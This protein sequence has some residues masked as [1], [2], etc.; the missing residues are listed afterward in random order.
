MQP[1]ALVLLPVIISAWSTYVRGDE[2]SSFLLPSSLEESCYLNNTKSAEELVLSAVSCVAVLEPKALRI[3]T[4][5]SEHSSAVS[6]AVQAYIA[7]GGYN[8]SVHTNIGGN[9][10]TF[11]NAS[12]E[13][14]YDILSYH[15]GFVVDAEAL[16]GVALAG[17]AAPL[18][19]YI[20]QDPSLN[21]FRISRYYR[22][23]SALHEQQTYGVPLG[24]VGMLSFYRQDVFEQ[25]NM[26]VPTTWGEALD[27]AKRWQSRNL[28]A[29]D[30]LPVHPFCGGRG[31][32]CGKNLLL[33]IAAPHLQ[34]NGPSSGFLLD[35]LTGKLL[36]GSEAFVHSLDIL[37]QLAAYGPAEDA[38]ECTP[39]WDAF[40]NGTCLL[41]L[42]PFEMFKV[43]AGPDSAVR[44]KLG[45]APPFGTFHALNRT[46]GQMQTCTTSLCPLAV[47]EPRQQQLL[48]E[49]LAYEDI[50]FVSSNSSNSSTSYALVNYAPFMRG[51]LVGLVSR[52]NPAAVQAEVVR[53]FGELSS[54]FGLQNALQPGSGIAPFRTDHWSPA[55]HGVWTGAGY[56]TAAVDAVQSALSTLYASSN[57][58]PLLRLPGHREITRLLVG[59]AEMLWQG[60]SPDSIAANVSAAAQ[61]VLDSYFPNPGADGLPGYL[62]MY[63]AQIGYQQ[64][65]T[66]SPQP[67]PSSPPSGPTVSRQTIVVIA[68][69]TGTAGL[70]ALVVALEV[71]NKRQHKNLLGRVKPPQGD[72]DTTIVV[73][74]IQDFDELWEA[75]ISDASE[76]ALQQ[77]GELVDGLLR[78]HSGYRAPSEEEDVVV[79]FHCPRDACE[80]ALDLQRGLLELRWPRHVLEMEQFKPQ[81]LAPSTTR[82]SFSQGYNA[83]RAAGGAPVSGTADDDDK[84]FTLA[85]RAD[86]VRSFGEQCVASWVAADANTPDAEL[87]FCGIRA[88]VGLCAVG[89]TRLTCET[90]PGLKRKTFSGEAVDVA[91]AAAAAA[92]GG[93]VLIPQSTFRQ[94]HLEVLAE[95]CLFCHLGEYQL[96]AQLPPMDLY[97]ALDRQLLGRLALFGPLSCHLQWSQGA[98]AA[99]VH[100]A[101]MVFTH[102]VGVQTLLAWD[103]DLMQDVIETFTRL[104]QVELQQAGGYLVEHVEGFMLTAFHS[105]AD[106]ILWGLRMQE[107]MLKEDWP[108]ELLAHELCE[109]VTVTVPVRGGDVTSATVFRGPR[110]KTGIDIGQVLARLHTM[111]GRMTYRGKVMNRAA[112]I[113]AAASS[114]Q[115]LCSAEAWESC[116]ASA[117][118]LRLVT[119]TSLGLFQLK[120]IQERIE[121]FHCT[122][123]RHVASS[124]RRSSTVSV[125]LLSSSDNR[126]KSAIALS[127]ASHLSHHTTSYRSS[128]PNSSALEHPSASEGRRGSAVSSTQPLGHGSVSG[129]LHSVGLEQMAGGILSGGPVVMGGGGGG[130]TSTGVSPARHRSVLLLGDAGAG[131]A[132]GGG[133]GAMGCRTFSHTSQNSA[134]GSGGAAGASAAR[135]ALAAVLQ[136]RTRSAS[137]LHTSCGLAPF[138]SNSARNRRAGPLAAAVAAAAADMSSDAQAAAAVAAAAAGAGRCFSPKAAASLDY[139]SHHRNAGTSSGEDGGSL[140]AGFGVG[141]SSGGGVT[142]GE[143]LAGGGGAATVYTVLPSVVLAGG[144]MLPQVNSHLSLIDETPAYEGH[145]GGEEEDGGQD[146]E[147][148]GGVGGG[149]GGGDGG[150]GAANHIVGTSDSTNSGADSAAQDVQ[151]ATI[152]AHVEG[153]DA[154]LAGEQAGG[155]SNSNQN[156]AQPPFL[157]SPLTTGSANATATGLAQGD[158]EPGFAKESR[159]ETLDVTVSANGIG[160]GLVSSSSAN[161]VAG[162]CSNDQGVISR[163]G[164][165]TAPF[166]YLFGL[167]RNSGGVAS[168]SAG[169]GAGAGCSRTSSGLSTGTGA[170]NG[171]RQEEPVSRSQSA[172]CGVNA[173]QGTMGSLQGNRQQSKSALSIDLFLPLPVAA[174]GV[175]SG[176]ESGAA[177][178]AGD[179]NCTATTAAA[180]ASGVDVSQN[181]ARA[182]VGAQIGHPRGL[183]EPVRTPPLTSTTAGIPVAPTTVRSSTP[184]SQQRNANSPSRNR[185]GVSE[186]VS[187][188]ATAA[189]TAALSAGAANA[190]GL[191]S[192][193]SPPSPSNGP[194]KPAAQAGA[195]A[196]STSKG[197]AGTDGPAAYSA[198]ACAARSAP[199]AGAASALMPVNGMGATSQNGALAT[200]SGA[201]MEDDDNGN[202]SSSSSDG[203]PPDLAMVSTG[204]RFEDSSSLGG[205]ESSRGF[206][207]LERPIRLGGGGGGGGGT[208]GG[209]IS[210]AYSTFMTSPL[211]MS[212]SSAKSMTQPL[213]TTPGTD[214]TSN[215]AAD[216]TAALALAEVVAPVMAA[217]AAAASTADPS[218]A[219]VAAAGPRAGPLDGE[220]PRL[221]LPTGGLATPDEARSCGGDAAGSAAVRPGTASDAHDY[222]AAFGVGP[223]PPPP[224]PPKQQQHQQKLQQPDDYASAA[225]AFGVGLPPT[226][227]YAAAASA[228]GIAPPAGV[229]GEDRVSGPTREQM[230]RALE[231]L[232]ESRH[233]GGGWH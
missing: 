60:E 77:F 73:A 200:P 21:W 117:S 156:P 220:Q 131:G 56:H 146:D 171:V 155:S 78:R 139:P 107:L 66:P 229:Y 178:G 187:A 32:Y 98:F 225:V 76:R 74:S 232:G 48:S 46:S 119:A 143:G 133:G 96:T 23:F 136:S 197:H 82:G 169:G 112:R 123:Q 166:S 5:D 3:Y 45:V 227:N 160:R 62:E 210:P 43:Y 92:Q 93:M 141:G 90:E 19:A 91:A 28:S 233:G 190:P 102:L 68:V 152:A 64:Q 55:T 89:F 194:T 153:V 209:G 201:G 71:R 193:M 174:G 108:E 39:Q 81:Y 31:S 79:A 219:A 198:P 207:V 181:D 17:L 33:A 195:A 215:A 199:A 230:E 126:R 18:D 25:L 95:K 208:G 65:A 165:V 104:A 88:R 127:S 150:R 129:A 11:L 99:P 168:G 138:R 205:A 116:T 13:L 211:L 188:F 16:P 213:R 203:A 114:G 84:L 172:S 191:A 97:L 67:S 196:A 145:A 180:A 130:L 149:S 192:A 185:S 142:G 159:I 125:G 35:P 36:L 115:V 128:M 184:H 132:G 40:S 83:S 49:E 38:Q 147:P 110:L 204:G 51:G 113:S 6:S 37:Q 170:S 120:G 111:T 10:D 101:S 24:G 134:H 47:Y 183:K 41:T 34:T 2:C 9:S 144:V 157:P 228:F 72:P 4:P 140:A 206:R 167:S 175:G 135:A 61:A 186:A 52:R 218:P 122:Y 20:M 70:L 223:P 158:L 189:A 217:A 231:L 100:A 94:L 162:L 29:S 87:A 63:R 177:P 151:L 54:G 176:Q 202:S 15:D 214:T 26:S 224:P 27:F 42:Q 7:N 179:D 8:V 59:A 221:G 44:S 14:A 30:G 86:N 118:A 121:V 1:W 22:G 50:A 80:F 164:S 226:S 137:A 161:Y 212:S 106:A 109:E 163:A 105:P 85:T 222:A 103:Y 148:I 154:Y 216:G 12:L 58:A 57:L 182:T 69:V 53:F 173:P 124:T 75:L